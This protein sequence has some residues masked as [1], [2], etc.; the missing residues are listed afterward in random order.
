[1]NEEYDLPQL[2]ETQRQAERPALPGIFYEN[3]SIS[4]E[5][6][7]QEHRSSRQGLLEDV[8]RLPLGL[9]GLLLALLLIAAFFAGRTV[10]PTASA[11]SG[12]GVSMTNRAFSIYY[13]TEYRRSL[14]EMRQ[15]GTLVFDPQ[16][17]L[18]R[19]YVDMETGRTWQ[20]YFM[21]QAATA[22]AITQSLCL[23]AR[24]AGYIL[25]EARQEA[26]AQQLAAAEQAAAANGFLTTE[27]QSDLDA[28]VKSL[29][30]PEATARD[31]QQYLFDSQLS[32]AYAAYLYQNLTVS[33]R[34]ITDY[35]RVHPERYAGLDVEA[36]PNVNVRHILLLSAGDGGK[37]DA[38]AEAEAQRLLQQCR[39]DGAPFAE[40]IFLGLVPEYSQDAGSRENGGLLENVGPGQIGGAFDQW[41]FTPERQPGDTAVVSS[42][43]G[44]HV[45]YF[46]GFRENYQWKEQVAEDLR[47][48]RMGELYAAIL[49]KY[50]CRL[51]PLAGIPALDA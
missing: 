6:Y 51:T 11:M 42:Q 18:T 36:T 45:L 1:M 30:G 17:P 16:R 46:L 26:F 40:Q 35:Y 43:Y 19:Q 9:C 50:Q 39:E 8:P 20:D 34:E 22:A 28:Y 10:D 31:F 25:P 7:E 38:A 15:Q 44:W 41:C 29:Y 14:A 49:E 3:L 21:E 12:S 37:T 47:S 32:E 48:E 5:I 23:E 33:E 2:P 13:W 27:G 4:Q 24:Q